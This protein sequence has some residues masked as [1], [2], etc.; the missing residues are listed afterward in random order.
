LE[1]FTTTKVLNRWQARWAQKLAGINFRIHYWL[2]SRNG[3]PDALSRR[4][5][6][7]PEK[8]GSVNQPITTVLKR[9]H[10]AEQQAL[11]ERKGK[12]FICS[13]IRLASIPPR[14]WPEEFTSEVK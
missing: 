14:K 6:Y 12:T 1:Y 7:S 13:S 9:E 10:F 4:S 11:E 5:E 3:K 8:G 2:G